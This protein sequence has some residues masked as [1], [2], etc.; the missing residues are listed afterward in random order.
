MATIESGIIEA[1]TRLLSATCGSLQTVILVPS[2]KGTQIQAT[3]NGNV[4]AFALPY[5]IEGLSGPV[6]VQSDALVN[7]I[8]GR[9]SVTLSADESSILVSTGNYK[10]TVH[11]VEHEALAFA[12]LVD[13]NELEFTSEVQMFLNKTLPRLKI[14]RAHVALPE[15]MVYGKLAKGSAF[16]STYD[17]Y[18]LC[19][20]RAKPKFDT[21]MEFHVPYAKFQQL[22]K[23]VQGITKMQL[24]AD[25]LVL[26]AKG[27]KAQIA[28]PAIDAEA[29]I[30]PEDLLARSKETSKSEGSAVSISKS[31]LEAFIANSTSL[32]HTG[33][34]IVFSSVK[35][36]VK[37]KLETPKGSTQAIIEADG[38]IPT[39]GLDLRFVSS[40]IEK[41]SEEKVTFEVV[42]DG[43]FIVCKGSDL[44]YVAVL[45]TT[46]DNK[47]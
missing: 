43:G 17:S 32:V 13:A 37:V 18:Q 9:A 5:T 26:Y 20:V 41:S 27:F 28:L 2:K 21:S 4:A 34:E 44:A 3:S 10:A 7:V 22:I 11:V 8:K 45:S 30:S 1:A 31:D 6:E 46:G 29:A 24:T 35:G 15:V 38:K 40:I 19:F 33:S 16:L 14:E 12:E 39:F 36:K 47:E 23:D 42:Q 25:T